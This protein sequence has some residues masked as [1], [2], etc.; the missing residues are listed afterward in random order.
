MQRNAN[1]IVKKSSLEAEVK[2]MP[3]KSPLYQKIYQ[4]GAVLS[5]VA[6]VAA[7]GIYVKYFNFANTIIR[8]AYLFFA[9]L[10]PVAIICANCYISCIFTGIQKQQRK[11]KE[12]RQK[13][14]AA[15]GGRPDEL[16]EADIVY[17]SQEAALRKKIKLQRWFMNPICFSGFFKLLSEKDFAMQMYIGYIIEALVLSLPAVIL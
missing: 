10:H 12:L 1:E 16:N 15:H 3:M 4:V 5:T 13:Q 2:G 9:V 8:T 6:A 11:E 14:L 17:L 7:N